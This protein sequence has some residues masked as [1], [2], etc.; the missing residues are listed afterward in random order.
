MDC[1][2]LRPDHRDYPEILTDATV[3]VL[4]AGG[5]DRWSVRALARW[6]KVAPA[7]VLND[8]SRSRVL[9]IVIICFE[10]RWLAWSASEAMY[11]PSPTSLPLRLPVSEDEKLG[12][13]VHGALRQLAEAERL[14]GNPAPTAHLARLRREEHE[15]LRHR[16]G[17]LAGRQGYHPPS[18]AAVTSTMA[19][20]TGLRMTLADPAAD[21]DWSDA[22]AALLQHV[23]RHL[24]DAGRVDA[25]S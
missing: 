22:C 14:R 21:L 23:T 10:R 11:G 5:I 20:V 18:T 3:H 16:L 19:L 6:M 17:Q 25:A 24:E 8:Y 1:P 13:R 2:F 7:A 4:G 12:V 15:L 9:E